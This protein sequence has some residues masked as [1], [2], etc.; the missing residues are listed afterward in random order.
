[1]FEFMDNVGHWH[2]V[3]LG[4]ILLGLELLGTTGFLLGIASSALVVGLV[5]W[6]FD[7][8]GVQGQVLL[9]AILSLVYSWVWFQ[10]F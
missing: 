7:S 3:T 5:T 4:L 2:W 9:F 6:V 1:M 8:F 10:Y